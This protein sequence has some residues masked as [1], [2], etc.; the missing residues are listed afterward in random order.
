MTSAGGNDIF[1]AKYSPAGAHQ[2]SRRI[3]GTST[4]DGGTGLAVDTD[5][6][7][8]LAGFI[9]RTVD[10]GTG[11]ITSA[12]SKDVFVARYSATGTPLAA[13][14]FGSTSIDAAAAVAVDASG[15]ALVCGS[16]F[17]TIDFGTGPLTSAGDA[18]LFLLRYGF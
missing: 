9:S 13:Q 16:F 4:Y 7:V 14:R 3:G 17:G 1:L 18:D 15:S 12:G 5:G 11:S 6:N 8:V 10:F 2:W